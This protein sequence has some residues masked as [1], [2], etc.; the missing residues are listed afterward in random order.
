MDCYD[1]MSQLLNGQLSI[2]YASA[3]AHP[4]CCDGGHELFTGLLMIER[5]GLAEDSNQ[6]KV[7]FEAIM[8]ELV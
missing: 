1:D 6:D 7:R 2:M 3:A 4:A 8:A 5:H